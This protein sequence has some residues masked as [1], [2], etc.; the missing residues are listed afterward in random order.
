MSNERPQTGRP[1]ITA[2]QQDRCIRIFYLRNRTV[3]ATHTACQ[4]IP[5]LRRISAKTVH[6][7]QRKVGLRARRPYLV[8]SWV[9]NI[10][11]H[12]PNGATQLGTGL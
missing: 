7:R 8:L 6:N 5:G 1:R 3:T 10:G 4:N 12:G 2:A 11:V 9:Y